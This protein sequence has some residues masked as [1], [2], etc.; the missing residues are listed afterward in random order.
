MKRAPSAP[1]SA[2]ALRAAEALQQRD[3]SDVFLA[4]KP[5]CGGAFEPKETK[6]QKTDA[7]Q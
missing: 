3:E 2:P 5:G 1:T 4:P 7:G 6:T